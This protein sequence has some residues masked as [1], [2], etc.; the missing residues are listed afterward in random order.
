MCGSGDE[1]EKRERVAVGGL[2]AVAERQGIRLA[3]LPDPDI[4][5]ALAGSGFEQSEKPWHVQ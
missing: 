4:V 3:D 1:A 5:G 2:V